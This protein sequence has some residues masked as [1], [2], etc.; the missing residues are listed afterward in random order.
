[1]SAHTDASDAASYADLR[2]AIEKLSPGAWYGV[3]SEGDE[4][5]SA[6]TAA[7]L[8]EADPKVVLALLDERDVLA[9][10]VAWLANPV[11]H[12]AW[13]S[14]DG[15]LVLDG[16]GFRAEAEETDLP[17]HLHAPLL[18]LVEEL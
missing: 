6:R 3:W 5:L 9:E 11:E 8:N 13:Y 1:M 12:G 2:Y 17:E 18:A 4:V 10:L 14:E 15:H 7:Y 16:K